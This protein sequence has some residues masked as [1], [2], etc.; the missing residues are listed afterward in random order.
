MKNQKKHL[1]RRS[2]IP[3]NLENKDLLISLRLVQFMK[4]NG[5][6]D[7]EMALV[8]R[9]GQMELNTLVSGLKIKPRVKVDLF[10]LMEISMMDFG[11]TIK[12]TAT[13]F[14]NILMGLSMK[15]I[16][17]MIYNMAMVLKLGLMVVD[18]KVNTALEENME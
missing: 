10:M 9:L 13:V 4:D 15:V 16:G 11:L 3:N 17:K 6:E 1:L 5:K 7:S 14:I 2:L 12:L 18:M 8:N